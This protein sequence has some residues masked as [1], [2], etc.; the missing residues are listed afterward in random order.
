MLACKWRYCL[1]FVI[2]FCVQMLSQRIG[3]SMLKRKEACACCGGIDIEALL[4]WK[5]ALTFT[6]L[7]KKTVLRSFDLKEESYQW[8]IFAVSRFEKRSI[9][10]HFA[11]VQEKCLV[12]RVIVMRSKVANCSHNKIYLHSTDTK[13]ELICL[14]VY[15]SP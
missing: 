5:R 11:F 2:F 12:S 7:R 8:M 13:I 10:K 15:F 9:K 4:S 3:T 1:N 14:G 6:L